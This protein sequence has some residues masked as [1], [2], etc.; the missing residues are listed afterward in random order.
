MPK[1]LN[2]QEIENALSYLSGWTLEKTAKKTQITRTFK[3]NDFKGAFGF[4][5]RVAFIMEQMNHHAEMTNVYNTVRIALTT[6]DTGNTISDLDIDMAQ[7][8]ERALN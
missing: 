2:E 4:M 6:H 1:Q 5:S 7:R 8:I 3:F